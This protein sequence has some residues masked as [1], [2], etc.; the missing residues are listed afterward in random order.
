MEDVI[1]RCMRVFVLVLGHVEGRPQQEQRAKSREHEEAVRRLIQKVE[2]LTA[3]NSV[4]Y[5]PPDPAVL[6]SFPL[7]RVSLYRPLCRA[8][9]TVQSDKNKPLV[10]RFAVGRLHLLLFF[11]THTAPLVL[12]RP[13]GSSIFCLPHYFLF[14]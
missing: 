13:L 12:P 3:A 1:Q 6:M 8:P 2:L 10:F 5:V 14:V 4:Q 11:H 7:D 9:M